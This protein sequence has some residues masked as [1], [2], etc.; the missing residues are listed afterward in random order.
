M[1]SLPVLFSLFSIPI[2]MLSRCFCVLSEKL[3]LSGS[4]SIPASVVGTFHRRV[5][6]N[7]DMAQKMA[8]HLRHCFYY[9]AG[10][11]DFSVVGMMFFECKVSLPA[12]GR[13]LIPTF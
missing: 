9:Y 13:Y 4:R 11:V 8:H 12:W 6:I 3:V 2:V 7:Y 1:Y 5:A 10:G